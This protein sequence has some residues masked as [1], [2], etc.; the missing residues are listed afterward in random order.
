MTVHEPM[1]LAT[2]YLL[3]VAAAIFAAKL[4]HTHRMWALAFVF[5]AL[6]SF[7]GGTYH[8]LWQSAILWK[9]TVLS[10]G[11]ASFFLL[12]AFLPRIA[13][14]KLVIYTSWMIFHDAFLW[15]IV[16]YGIT[17]LLVGAIVSLRRGPATR[18]IRGSIG[19]SVIGAV[20]Q[21]TRLTLHPHFNYNDLYHVIQL[22]ALW[23]LYRGGVN[24]GSR[25]RVRS[26]QTSVAA[27]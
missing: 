19:L 2:D 26:S 16:D 11:F 15:V 6:G 3:T 9:P 1:T 12:A 22:V 23:L 21:Q 4:W 8:G 14:V 24:L 5:T 7:F 10:I 17:L 13:I 20:V 25:S 27:L 18:W